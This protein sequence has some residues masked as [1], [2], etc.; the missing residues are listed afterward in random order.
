MQVA[1]AMPGRVYAT[2]DAKTGRMMASWTPAGD[3][4][5]VAKYAVT[6]FTTV[7]SAED[8]SAALLVNGTQHLALVDRQVSWVYEREKKK[9]GV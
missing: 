9:Y 4:V 3:R 2:A 5:R 6:P 8:F 1:L 7:R